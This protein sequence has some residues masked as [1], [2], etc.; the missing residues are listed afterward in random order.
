MLREIQPDTF[1]ILGN[2]QTDH[3]IPLLENERA[4]KAAGIING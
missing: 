4:R 3:K 1:L 2:T